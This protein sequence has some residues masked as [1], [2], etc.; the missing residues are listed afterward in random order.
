MQGRKNRSIHSPQDF[1]LI[2]I[3]AKNRRLPY[4]S[5]IDSSPRSR[6]VTC[7]V[8]SSPI[9]PSPPPERDRLHFHRGRE[10]NTLLCIPSPFDCSIWSRYSY[11]LFSVLTGDDECPACVELVSKGSREQQVPDRIKLIWAAM[12]QLAPDT[13]NRIFAELKSKV[14]DVRIRAAVDLFAHVT[15]I[16]RGMRSV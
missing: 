10:D 11:E 4:I 1:Y 7:Q 6:A 9:T 3:C 2:M 12:A 14:E 8:M 5:C 15:V 16:V 13:L